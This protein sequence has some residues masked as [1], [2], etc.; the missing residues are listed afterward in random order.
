MATLGFL[1]LAGDLRRHC[2]RGHLLE[3]RGAIANPFISL[4]CAAVAGAAGGKPVKSL[5]ILSDGENPVPGSVPTKRVING[6]NQMLI[7]ANDDFVI[8]TCLK[9]TG[10]LTYLWARGL[11]SPRAHS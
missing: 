2:R 9:T 4:D 10:C 5:G 11:K 1:R 8:K 7:N 6:T 3:V